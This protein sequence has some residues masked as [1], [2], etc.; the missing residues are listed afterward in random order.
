LAQYRSRAILRLRD[1]V[2]WPDLAR[3]DVQ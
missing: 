1:N 2:A 3:E